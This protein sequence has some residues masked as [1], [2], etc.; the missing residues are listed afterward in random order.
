MKNGEKRKLG[1]MAK[2]HFGPDNSSL[3]NG[4]N[5]VS[6]PNMN[7]LFENA[8]VKKIKVSGQSLETDDGGMVTSSV[9][10]GVSQGDMVF[11]MKKN[12]KGETIDS[13]YT[14]TEVKGA[15]KAPY[16][17]PPSIL[18]GDYKTFEAT[19]NNIKLP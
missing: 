3:G 2:Q 13:D 8:T 19:E 15:T 16:N 6:K 9:Y 4:S 1:P 17:K 18:A 5:G 7:R 10:N 12:S 14:L 11:G